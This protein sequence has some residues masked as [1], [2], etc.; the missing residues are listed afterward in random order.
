MKLQHMIVIFLIIM[1]PLAL[2]MSQYT[3]LQ[4][5][6]LSAKTKCDTALLSATF[7]TMSAFEL[8]TVNNKVSSVIGEEIRD[9]EA[10]IST[11]ATSLSSNLGMSS[12][13]TDNVLSHVPALVFG[14][15]DGYYIYAQNDTGT[16]RE[17]KPY[18]YYTKTYSRG[19]TDITIAY[20]LDNYVSIYGVYNGKMI[21]ESG[22]L[23]IPGD[24][25]ISPD[26]AY[27]TTKDEKLG[28]IKK[29]LD[30]GTKIGGQKSWVRYKGYDIVKETIYENETLS[31]TDGTLTNKSRE[32]TDAMMYYYEALQFTKIYNEVVSNLN[33]AD[34]NTLYIN[35][36]NDPEDEYSAFMNEKV[37]VM[38]SS[39]TKNLNTAIYN[40]E[41]GVSDN[42]EMP[43]LKG[44]DWEKILNNV[45]I[46]AFLKDMQIGTTKYNNYVVVNSTTNQKYNS[47][48]SIDFIEY[49]NDAHKGVTSYGY[50]HKITCDEL[51]TNL[52]GRVTSQIIGYAAVDFERYRYS[53]E[54]SD[55]YFYYYK[56]N[57]YADYACEVEALENQNVAT[58]EGY[59][60]GKTTDNNTRNT[61]LKAYYTAVGRIRNTQIKASSYINLD[62]PKNF[63]VRY[64]P[65]G[66]NWSKGN[67]EKVTTTIGKL[68]TI[69]DT[70][71]VTGKLF[72]GWSINPNSKVAEVKVGDTIYG[73]EGKTID[74]YA[75]FADQ[76]LI[77]YHMNGGEGGPSPNVQT[78]IS[79]VDYKI[80]TSKP[81]R[82]G[83]TFLGWSTNPA[84]TTAEYKA[85]DIYTENK[86]L[87][88]YAVWTNQL[89]KIQ[90]NT[91]GGS[92]VPTQEKAVG[93]TIK[94]EGTPTLLGS[95]FLGWSRTPA[96]TTPDYQPGSD[97]SENVDRTLY[98]IWDTTTFRITFN[99]NGGNLPS[100]LENPTN[101]IKMYGYGYLIPS[102]KPVRE[103]YNFI[104]WSKTPNDVAPDSKYA[105][106]SVYTE[107]ADLNLYAVWQ[108][109]QYSVVYDANGGTNAPEMQTSDIDRDI[110]I[111][112]DKP[113]KLGYQ[114]KGWSTIHTEVEGQVQYKSGQSYTARTSIRLYAVWEREI[115]TITYDANG[116]TQAPANQTKKYGEN[117]FITSMQPIKADYY[118]VGWSRNRDSKTVEYYTNQVYKENESITLYAIWS[119]SRFYSITYYVNG[120]EGEPD[121]QSDIPIETS[122]T[123]SSIRPNRDG[124]TFLG[125][126]TNKTAT[127]ADTRYAPGTTY[128]GPLDLDLY[129]VWQPIGHSLTVN[130]NGGIWRGKTNSTI[131]PTSSNALMEIENPTPP[132]GWRFNKWVVSKGDALVYSESATSWQ[133]RM[134]LSSSTIVAQYEKEYYKITYNS[135]SPTP[136]GNMPESSY[137]DYDSSIQISASN[138]P[139]RSGYRFMGWSESPIATNA[140]YGVGS[141][142]KMPAR[143][144]TLYAVWRVDDSTP[145]SVTITLNAGTSTS[146]NINN[147]SV[148]ATI[149]ISDLSGV[150]IKKYELTRSSNSLGTS[151]SRYSNSLSGDNSTI[152]L[153]FGETGTYYLHVLAIDNNGNAIETISAQINVGH[154]GG[155]GCGGKD[156][157]WFCSECGANQGIGNRFGTNHNSGCSHAGQSNYNGCDYHTS[158]SQCSDWHYAGYSVSF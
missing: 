49:V 6:T 115:Y 132:V 133:I 17:L 101:C 100:D 65:N 57:E 94:L 117:I 63:A 56:H 5:D 68:S 156:A 89:V 79:G 123:I 43:Q 74:L 47:A 85:G 2:I 20:S 112:N 29:V 135:N 26:F 84:A 90:Y 98:A 70:P 24:V 66:G 93:A 153:R 106:G 96:G 149:N 64:Y 154:S 155:S 143:N 116:G 139:T 31:E 107:N 1:L 144:M 53:I 39:I 138:S 83:R 77:T 45:S 114:F 16:G 48:K 52:E 71:N 4:I 140:T 22:Y 110:I 61:I 134:L 129:A 120:G 75:V 124:Y 158:P 145:P 21:S 12:A 127:V 9:L 8:N 121:V 91:K 130:P 109:N 19:S 42:Y 131:V 122:T 108:G 69:S 87:V 30:P 7:D 34:T 137:K 15:Y 102:N 60:K 72:M 76:Y 40:Y 38:K 92:V 27:V 50:Y 150:A 80:S 88:L 73:Q 82:D 99:A 44:E 62:K 10:V 37:N 54:D 59:I 36:D 157:M 104:G 18:V 41:G 55:D 28:T 146:E 58:I 95:T 51:I 118:F 25:E 81:R 119:A 78:K 128:R 151:E 35:S 147:L 141:S 136:V 67:P 3:S 13:S 152:T 23:I 32:T 142:F 113:I 105:P 33:L 11:F 97:Y 14:L 148:N 103:G 126:S 111:T 125:W 86:D 46:T